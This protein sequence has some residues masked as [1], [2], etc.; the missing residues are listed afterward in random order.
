MGLKSVLYWIPITHCD[1]L[2]LLFWST[3]AILF[4]WHE[5]PVRHAVPRNHQCQVTYNTSPRIWDSKWSSRWENVVNGRHRF[6]SKQ[7]NWKE[8]WIWTNYSAF[9]FLFRWAFRVSPFQLQ[10]VGGALACT[11]VTVAIRLELNTPNPKFLTSVDWLVFCILLW[12]VN[13]TKCTF[14]LNL[15]MSSTKRKKEF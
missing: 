7:L 13:T 8:T 3:P 10:A 12:T 14:L 11:G 9:R 6:L 5:P 4:C 15:E 2:V 1:T